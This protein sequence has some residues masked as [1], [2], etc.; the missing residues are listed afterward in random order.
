[1]ATRKYIDEDDADEDGYRDVECPEC[2]AIINTRFQRG[3]RW[4]RL[5]C[6]VCHRPVTVSAD[7]EE[8]L[9]PLIQID[10]KK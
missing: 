10:V 5:S 4:R 8:P 3:R 1:M 9:Q 2:G 6:P 7:S